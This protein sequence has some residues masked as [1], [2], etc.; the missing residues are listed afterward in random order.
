M[1]SISSDTVAIPAIPAIPA[2]YIE[3][4]HNL[5]VMQNQQLLKLIA[6]DLRIPYGE[7]VNRYVTTRTEFK[8]SLT[9]YND[10]S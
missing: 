5:I 1:Q 6:K 9:N 3:I 7:L 2:K 8:R 10:E 4:I